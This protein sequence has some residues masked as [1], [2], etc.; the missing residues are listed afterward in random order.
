M[1]KLI[2]LLLWP[3][4][5]GLS[6][7]ASAH[8]QAVETYYTQG[9]ST[10]LAKFLSL[11]SG[12]VP[13]SV[14]EILVL[15]LMVITAAGLIRSAWVSLKKIK[16]RIEQRRKISKGPAFSRRIGEAQYKQKKEGGILSYLLNFLIVMGVIYF[17]FIMIWG[18]N[19][20]RLSFAEIAGFKQNA[21]SE[22]ELEDLY[23]KLIHKADILRAGTEED[24]RGVMTMTGGFDETAQKAVQSYADAAYVYP[25]L[26]GKY[27]KPKPVFF[28]TAMSY[29]GISGIYFPFTAEAN[30]NVDI[31][32]SMLPAT[33]CH[34]LAHQRG[35]AREDEANYIAWVACNSSSDP[36][37]RYSGALLALIHTMNAYHR[38]YP[39]KAAEL[40]RMIGEGV[41]RDLAAISEY[42]QSYEGKIEEISS[43]IND[44]YLKSNHQQ[45]GVKS[46]G[47]MVDLLIAE[48]QAGPEK[49]FLP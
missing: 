10:A 8:P 26:A 2:V 32:D 48:Q 23:I 35:F 30:V 43:D 29:M 42:W 39:E 40:S 9:L 21:G 27:G 46:Y 49:R 24:N 44:T 20:N 36:D 18:L 17:T 31:P 22:A 14:A 4:G 1:R 5:Y 15:L 47:R 34:E 28:S 6:L 25:E 38:H 19:Y 12:V 11:V 33:T 41:R 45:D 3:A 13:L 37:F 16:T 7:L